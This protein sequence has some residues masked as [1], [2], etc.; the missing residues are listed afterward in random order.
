[1]TPKESLLVKAI[2][3]V[4]MN[5][6]AAMGI[7]K[8]KPP[9]TDAT[10]CMP[11]QYEWINDLYRLKLNE[12]LAGSAFY[13]SIS[14]AFYDVHSYRFINDYKFKE[15]ME[16]RM[17]SIGVPRSEIQIALNM[18]DEV[19]KEA[20]KDHKIKESSD[21]NHQ[22]MGLEQLEGGKP[23]DNWSESEA[24][25]HRDIEEVKKAF[26]PSNLQW[27][28]IIENRRKSGKLLIIEDIQLNNNLIN[29]EVV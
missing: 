9:I 15:A 27:L 5:D 19:L 20:K 6:P 24:G 14:S 10:N 13:E 18:V 25:W 28:T 7:V 2:H 22:N 3:N 1:M 21:S 4:F 17:R 12:N 11:H 8:G 29:N 26:S 23:S 16:A